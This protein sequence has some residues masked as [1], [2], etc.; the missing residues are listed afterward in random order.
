MRLA[1]FTAP[2]RGRERGNNEPSLNATPREKFER[3]RMHTVSQQ[4][5]RKAS[6]A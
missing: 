6:R 1:L 4:G 5:D 3:E 2:R